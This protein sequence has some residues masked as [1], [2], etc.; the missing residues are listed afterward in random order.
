M[1]FR[2]EKQED[3]KDGVECQLNAAIELPNARNAR[4]VRL[5]PGSFPAISTVVSGQ[6]R[7]VSSQ[8]IVRFTNEEAF[9]EW[10]VQQ[11]REFALSWNLYY[12]KDNSD[13][14]DALLLKSGSWPNDE[15]KRIE[16][17]FESEHRLLQSQAIDKANEV[18]NDRLSRLAQFKD[19]FFDLDH[20]IDA[21]NYDEPYKYLKEI[22]LKKKRRREIW[23][24]LTERE[25]AVLELSIRL[26]TQIH[27]I[28]GAFHSYCET[29]DGVERFDVLL[30]R[31]QFE[32]TTLS[33]FSAKRVPS[34]SK[35]AAQ[36]GPGV[37]KLV[38]AWF[39][40]N[41]DSLAEKVAPV[42]KA[43]HERMKTW[44]I[45]VEGLWWKTVNE[46]MPKA[47]PRMAQTRFDKSKPE[48]ERTLQRA[49]V[50]AIERAF[51]ELI[52]RW[53]RIGD[54]ALHLSLSP[55][56][57]R[58]SSQITCE[59]KKEGWK[60]AA[61]ELR[62]LKI[63]D[64]DNGRPRI[65][66]LGYAPLDDNSNQA[67]FF[68]VGTS[69]LVMVS[70]S[71]G[72]TEIS[73][74]N[75][76][77]PKGAF[78]SNS[79]PSASQTR[80]QI[81]HF[82]RQT[83]F[84]SFNPQERLIAFTTEDRAVYIYRFSAKFESME[85]TK[86]I[87]LVT[88]TS[89]GAIVDMVVAD[90]SIFLLD[91][92]GAVQSI[93]YRSLQT[94]RKVQKTTSTLGK[95]HSSL[96]L[97]SEGLGLGLLGLEGITESNSLELSGCLE[98]FSSED[99]RDIPTSFPKSVFLSRDT[100]AICIDNK[101]LV[102]DPAIGHVKL[103]TLDLTIRSDSYRIKHTNQ[104][105]RSQPDD[106]STDNKGEHWLRVL[107]HMYE[108][109]PVGGLIESVCDNS[110][111]LRLRLSTSQSLS[112]DHARACTDFLEWI[113]SDLRK[114]NKALGNVDVSR[115]LRIVSDDMEDSSDGW[116]SLRTFETHGF[117]QN[118][119]TFV[120]TQICRAEGNTLSVMDSGANDG[121]S[122]P[123]NG[124]R[125]QSADIA[126]SI[127]FGLLTPMLNAW[128][129]PVVVITS[130][131]KQSTG[132]S[133]LLNHLTGSSFAI[134]GARCTDGAWMNIRILPIG[135]MLIVLDFEGLG[136]FE[137]SEQEDV[138]LSVLNASISMFTIFRMEMRFDK[139]M[140]D[141][142]AR[143]QKGVALVK[144]DPRLFRGM[145]YMSVKDVNPNDQKSVMGEFVG[146]LEKLLGANR[147]HNFLTDLYTGRLE[148]NCSPPLGT[149]D[150]YK[151]L[152]HARHLIENE[153]CAGSKRT[154]FQ[155]GKTF[156][157][158][159]RLAL[160]KISI[161][162]W[163]SLDESA[164]QFMLSEAIEKLPGLLRSGNL[165]PREYV[166]SQEP[167]ANVTEALVGVED[168]FDA[169]CRAHPTMVEKWVLLTSASSLESL[170]DGDIDLG[171]DV[172][173]VTD[174]DLRTVNTALTLLLTTFKSIDTDNAGSSHINRDL[175]RF[176]RVF[177]SATL[178]SHNQLVQKQV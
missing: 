39:G 118:M 133:Y 38:G 165:I 171:F 147:E 116:K 81:R 23:D 157:D 100:S 13:F 98:V 114:L 166:S 137:R 111:S 102:L 43:F 36:Q 80:R 151:S 149:L 11:A 14:R 144:S 95:T 110:K 66:D 143:F 160:A 162:D 115:D 142:F 88:Q 51:D 101:L 89:L 34:P 107:Y 161:L 52:T 32:A 156:L 91:D 84:C 125:I 138:L 139:D 105:Q 42:V 148:I 72:K 85:P 26:K 132:K 56:P 58:G 67:W 71:A 145:L 93:N 113:M 94:S 4:D 48:S 37:L 131:G 96:L 159:I 129:G 1:G 104:K 128:Q 61:D 153:L 86:T 175:H 97:L 120:P 103:F 112:N 57:R 134:S 87:N 54:E 126:R 124:R 21:S 83:I 60:T 74:L 173:A 109:F 5:L 174:D 122:S 135:V 73:R 8:E 140:D 177:Y 106:A 146:K 24:E 3:Q 22:L 6:R 169:V 46:V 167:V 7:K 2:V 92:S 44:M 10:A 82:P 50:Q 150:Y 65:D 17:Q 64:S 28:Y 62:L 12:M 15:M 69:S 29:K 99:F 136:S 141:L 9:A 30:D 79:R 178:S 41:S 55:T 172:S 108:K 49:R 75:F 121:G 27:E 59:L 90:N 78:T 45:E 155:S 154:T 163:T 119:L 76:H 40:V 152:N 25:R 47:A 63:S 158:C 35:A 19:A 127:R 164:Q 33:S 68:T 117:V 20:V 70:A 130:M 176:P 170:R 53:K 168:T 123:D 18:V 16:A 31:S 77:K